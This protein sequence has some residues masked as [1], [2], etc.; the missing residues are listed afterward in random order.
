M[1]QIFPEA[2]DQ[3]WIDNYTEGTE[4]LTRIPNQDGGVSPRF[5]D[6]LIRSTVIE[7]EPDLRLETRWNQGYQQVREYAAGTVRSGTSVS[8]V[9]GI[10]SDTVAW[11]IFDV[12]LEAGIE[13]ASC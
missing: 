8:Q 4:A 11:Y 5:I 7:Y 9:R 10:L 13:P 1:R 12:Q 2:A 6:N 3:S